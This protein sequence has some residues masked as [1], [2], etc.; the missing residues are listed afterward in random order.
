MGSSSLDFNHRNPN[1][2]INYLLDK[3]IQKDRSKQKPRNYLGG[4]RLGHPCERAIQFEFFHAEPD[5]GK[6]FSGQT[7]R[8]FDVGHALEELAVKWIR[9]AGFDLRNQKPDGYQFGFSTAGGRIR[10]HIDGVICGGPPESGL[11]YPCL[12]E[13]KTMSA[14]H[15]RECV[16]DGVAKSKPVYAAQIAIYQAYMDLAEHPALFISINKDT[17]ELWFETVPFNAELA[18][19]MSDKGARIIQACDA[20][21]ILPRTFAAQDHFEC[22]FCSYTQRCWSLPV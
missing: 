6:G 9:S 14:K 11:E 3:A 7:L 19:R 20:G 1:E 15:W 4:S 10:G 17:Q 5:E 12:W 18:Q 21:E 13:C 2:R 8:I 16:K 22:R